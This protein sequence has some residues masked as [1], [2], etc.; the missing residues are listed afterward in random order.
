MDPILSI[1]GLSKEEQDLWQS[2]VQLWEFAK[3]RAAGAIRE[4]IHPRYC[5]WDMSQP[6]PHDR[7][8]A[9]Q[10]VLGESPQIQTYQLNPLS[11]Q[12][13][14]ESVGIV[15]YCYAAEVRMRDN[16]LLKITGKWTEIYSKD[17]G[18]WLLI[19]VSGRPDAPS[20]SAVDTDAEQA[21]TSPRSA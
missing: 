7:E 4:S 6:R 12:T 21:I 10:S 5:G 13:Y 11:I 20:G 3:T 2:V 14:G 17:T 18:D 15:H 1:E 16:S 8:A 19:G 9:L